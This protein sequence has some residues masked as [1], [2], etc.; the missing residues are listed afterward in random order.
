MQ[1][2]GQLYG[3][4]VANHLRTQLPRIPFYSTVTSQQLHKAEDFG[5]HY[6]RQ[7]MESP[8]W[9]YQGFNCLLRSE[10]GR[11][12]IYLEIGPHSAL[13]RPIKEIYRAQ[14]ASN[15]YV[16]VLTRGSN[17]VVSFLS[18]V[19]ELYSRGVNISYPLPSIRPKALH[20]LPLYPWH[21]TESLCSDFPPMRASRFQNFPSH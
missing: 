8:V 6:W 11:D 18:C 3:S 1:E 5:P 16:S 7:N 12:A 21:H 17:G 2:V 19:G 4:L 14:N 9:F 15:P 10:I 13:A 20:D